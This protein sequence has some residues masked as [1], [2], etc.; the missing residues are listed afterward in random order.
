M[1][2]QVELNKNEI[3]QLQFPVL[4]ETYERVKGSMS[5][6]RKYNEQFTEQERTTIAR[7]YKLFYKWHLVSGIPEN[8][9]MYPKT[10]ELLKRAINF[11]GTI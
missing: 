8:V 9:V 3:K 5:K 7:Y 10:L 4:V 6:R 2:V 11:F 1:K